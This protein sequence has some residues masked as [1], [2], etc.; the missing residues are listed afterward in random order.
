[1]PFIVVV[2]LKTDRETVLQASFIA[3]F[4]LFEVGGVKPLVRE[5]R[6]HCDDRHANERPD[7]VERAELREVME[8][9]LEQRHAKQSHRRI[10]RRR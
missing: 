4:F 1:M 10:T 8:E 7:A 3:R 5:R 2:D 6:E 9:Q